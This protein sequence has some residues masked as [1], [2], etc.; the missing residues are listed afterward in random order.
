MSKIK[1]AVFF[2]GKS[3]EHD[4]S[5]LTG[6]QSIQVMDITKY[7]PI[8]V[9]VDKDGLW[10]TGLELLNIKNYPIKQKIKSKLKQVYLKIGDNIT[11]PT[12]QIKNKFFNNKILFDIA[13]LSFHGSYG[14]NG[15]MQ[16]LFEIA[17]IA[18]TGADVLSSSVYMSKN[19]TKKICRELGINVLNDISLT[20]PSNEEFLDIKKLINDLTLDY[21]VFIKPANLGSSIGIYK[22]SNQKELTTSLLEVFKIDDEVIIEPYVENLVEYNIAVMKNN[23]GE[24]ITS[25]IEQPN[26][27]DD[28]LTFED[29]YLSS[30]SSKKKVAN[31]TAIP[32]DEL[33]E[34]RRIFKPTLSKEQETF[35]I[36][37]AKKLFQTMGATGSPRIDF[38]SNKKTGEIWLNEVNP[39][40]GANAFYLWQNSDYNINYTELIDIMIENGIKNYKKKEKNIDLKISSSVIFK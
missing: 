18:Y 9:Y 20:K 32:S 19:I 4:V 39:I 13:L 1:V 37:S 5:I 26:N 15:S 29:K 3:F 17:N 8:P 34:S 22:A 7:E 21:P 33:I 10:W 40:P 2:G 38:L 31:I 28:Y 23:A 25:V 24:I 12:L 27:K 14:E 16:G 35:I 11:K 36:T 6:L 30:D